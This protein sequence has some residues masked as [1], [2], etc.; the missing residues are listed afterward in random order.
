MS[1]K[2]RQFLAWIAILALVGLYA[3]TLIF[4]LIGSPF[5]QKMFQASLL[6]TL[7]IPIIIWLC[8]MAL[9]WS[10]DNSITINP[11]DEENL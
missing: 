7:V 4:S 9:R 8:M 5:A 10:E 1:K 3:A 6:C 2:I 11:D